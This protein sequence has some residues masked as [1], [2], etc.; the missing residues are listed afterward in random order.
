MALVV[1]V[2][3]VVAVAV[4]VRIRRIGRG[5]GRVQVAESEAPVFCA[6]KRAVGRHVER[7]Y[8]RAL[9]AEPDLEETALRRVQ[10]ET[11]CRPA[12]AAANS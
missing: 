10:H 6:Q 7:G 4:A 2:A 3:A 9:H 5:S 11:L 8:S 12:I 1:L